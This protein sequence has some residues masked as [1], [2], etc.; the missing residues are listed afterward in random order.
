[1][2]TDNEGR[3]AFR[4][5][6][7]GTYSLTA[8]KPGYATGAYG[9][10]RPEGPP[11]P[12]Q[13]DD[14]ERMGDAT[15]R[16]FKYASIAGMVNDED[17]EPIVGAQVRADR[18]G[19]RAGRR[20]LSQ[21]AATS[22]D[23]RGMYRMF[24]LTPG[25]Y[26][27]SIPIGSGS[28][29]ATGVNTAEARRNLSATSQ[30]L[31]NYAG[32]GAGG[33][34]SSPDSRFLLQMF[35]IPSAAIADGAG[36]WR[37]YATTYYP[38]SLTASNAEP[39]TVGSGEDRAGIDFA[40]RYVPASSISGV[41]V[42]P[43]GPAAQYVLR[44]IPTETGAWSA[45]AD[46]ASAVTD[47]S[48]A[49]TFL[50]VPAGRYV[51]Q[52]VKAPSDAST[53]YFNI[54]SA[55]SP[56]AVRFESATASAPP[57][58]PLL[59][60]M[61]PVTVGD[62]DVTGIALTLAEGLTVGGRL[63]F[64]GSKP[65]PDPQR[66]AQVPIV[67]ESADGRDNT[68]QNGPPSRVQPDGRFVSAPR[69]PGK[70]FVRVGGSPAGFIVQSVTVNG[71]DATEVPIDLT[72]SVTSVVITFTDLISSITGTVHG[73]PADADPPAVVLFPADSRGWKDFG[74][75]PSR[76]KMTRAGVQSS[77]FSFGSLAAGDYFAVAIRDEYSADWQNPSFLD[78]LSR[79]AQR[80]TLTPGEKRT[81]DLALSDVKPPSIGRLDQQSHAKPDIPWIPDAASEGGPFVAETEV[82]GQVTQQPV[83]DNRPPETAGTGSI[84]GVVTINDGSPR[85]ARLARVS[86]SGAG[87][88]GERAALTDDAGRF[89][90]AWLPAG[91]YQVAVTKPG[92]LM[93]FYGARRPAAGPGTPVHVDAGKPVIGI[94]IT[95]L[96]G[97]VISGVVIDALGAPA[98]GVRM[99][100]QTLTRR[101]GERVLTSG[102]A[103]GQM[104]TD[105]HG[106]YRLYGVRP[107]TYVISAVPPSPGSNVE[108]RQLSE[109]EIRAAIADAAKGAPPP[110]TPRTIAPAPPGDVPAIQGGG[111]SVGFSPIYYPGTPREQEAVELTLSP[112][113]ELNGINVQLML[114]P[115]ARLEGRVYGPNGQPATNV[116][117]ALQRYS[118]TSTTTT[119]VRQQEGFC[120]AVGVP[121][122]RYTLVASMEAARVPQAPGMPPSPAG[123]P[124]YAQQ[125]IE[126][127][128]EDQLNLAL[129]LV[130]ML[131]FSGRV[132]IDG[133]TPPDMRA[134][135][136]NL[137]PVG[138]VPLNRTPSGASPD[139]AGAFTLTG[140]M[141]GRYRLSASASSSAPGATWATLSAQ[142]D[143]QDGLVT[144]FEIRGDRAASSVVVTLTDH[145]AE[146]SGTLLDGADRPVAGMTMVIFP[147]DRAMWPANSSRVNRSTRSGPDGTYRFASTL[148]GEYYLVVVS[149]LDPNDWTDPAFKEQLVPAALKVM[150]GKGEKK[151]ENMK[152]K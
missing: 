114:V 133:A 80:F 146:I 132:V 84:S 16:L 5:L 61:A 126:V 50:A 11:R 119:S 143:G 128:G 96:R 102:Q 77:S 42:G 19:W 88:S 21:A 13:L 41:V 140:V 34:Q 152:I 117:L 66:L 2:L 151:T 135:R 69:V 95:M 136:V 20:V 15:V 82:T 124:Y 122:G 6:T 35:G 101:E 79:T 112:G 81:L 31:T 18:R 141:P 91:D 58:E 25:E 45:D 49:F 59:W 53:Y 90:I 37:M 8:T 108:V 60:A 98:P 142:I 62:S 97:A 14:N 3:F 111:R 7:R 129:S 139:Q 1:M 22:T 137:E 4:N 103:N 138:F 26:V 29:P 75:N 86:V 52:T 76:L 93:M 73:V 47:A 104:M 28:S 130:P 107:G 94:D 33:I 63:E 148:P 64:S 147:T 40:M 10:M 115:A 67:I 54:E 144:P 44:L 17:G 125:E 56:V 83:R 12:V 24:N 121:A 89:T 51:I 105:D 113:Q 131:T 123:N 48:G 36:R 23:D 39:I 87:L 116:Q 46:V 65:R 57:P 78:V 149:D 99:Q 38:G 32:A 72:S 120:Q 109:S 71:A 110:T 100:L 70:Y 85:P 127:T 134:V 92:F 30:M 43:N 145:P 55:Q 106:M 74:I 118:G 68:P 150:V 9:R 27:V